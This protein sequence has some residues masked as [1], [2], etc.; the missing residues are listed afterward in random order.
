MKILKQFSKNFR[1]KIY[2]H[3]YR[4][5]LQHGHAKKLAK[6]YGGTLEYYCD[7]PCVFIAD[8]GHYK[9]PYVDKEDIDAL[10]NIIKIH[11]QKIDES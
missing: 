7:F 3:L 10:R 1:Y 5:N 2:K 11:M 6:A 4:K 8:K 9:M